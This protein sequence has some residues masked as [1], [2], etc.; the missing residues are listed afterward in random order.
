MAMRKG[1]REHKRKLG[2]DWDEKKTNGIEKV[3][4]ENT[5]EGLAMMGLRRRQMALRKWV[6]RTLWRDW[7]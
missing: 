7:Q 2:N 1:A 3:G 5:M 6:R 4:H